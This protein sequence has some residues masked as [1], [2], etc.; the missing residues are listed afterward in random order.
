MGHAIAAAAQRRGAQVVLVTTADR[1]VAAG[2]RGRAVETAE[3]MRD[4][5]L[6][7]ADDCDV[8]VMAA[9]VADFRPKAVAAGEV[10]EGRRRARDR[11]RADRRHPRR[12]RARKRAD[13]VVVG[14]AAETERVREHA[15]AKLA[16]KQVDL[17]VA[18]DVSADDAG[19]EVDTNRVLV[20]DAR[21]ASRRL[22]LMTKDALAD[23]LVERV[24]LR[25]GRLATLPPNI[26]PTAGAPGDSDR[27]QGRI[28]LSKHTFTS[29]S[30]TEGHPDKMAD[31]ISDSVLDAVL[32]E[33]PYGR[34]ACET[35]VT[36]G[37]CVVA[38][39][40]S[41][42]AHLDIAR[43]ARD[44]I[45]SIGY[46]DAA[47][48]IDGKTCGVI[49]SVDEQSPDIAMGVDKAMEQRAGQH[50]RLRRGR[51]RRPGHDVRLRVRRD[52]RADA[53][54]D[55]A[56]APPGRA[57]RAGPQG[58]RRRLPP[59]RRQDAG[60]GRVRRR[61]AG[62]PRHGAHLHAARSRASASRATSSPRSSST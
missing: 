57:A 27:V 13:Q 9:A 21:A 44:T 11:A 36:T 8:V 24:A 39:E 34:V 3:Q 2:H 23:W 19:F 29:E 5:V 17:M 12:A 1:P 32:T 22:P 43:I 51:R 20:L 4:A 26:S 50:R 53:D 46:T 28:G 30:V 10:Q 56:R 42:K 14:F 52:R 33:D 59:A 45:N 25:L 16:A 7:I 15:A 49:I 35:L 41:T 6:G 40:I 55:L 31:Q 54:A 48:G 62:P 47:F 37:L 61:R 58:P 18:N 38:G 60:L